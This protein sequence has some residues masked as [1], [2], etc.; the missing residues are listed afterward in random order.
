[1]LPLINYKGTSILY[2]ADLMP[3]LAHISLPWVMAY[4]MRPLDT[5]TE[6]EMI[7]KDIRMI[8]IVVEW[9]LKHQEILE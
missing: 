7:L 1:M 5:L 9:I 2:C 3:S 4:D 8:L 6:K